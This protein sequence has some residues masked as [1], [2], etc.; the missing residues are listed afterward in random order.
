MSQLLQEENIQQL[1]EQSLNEQPEQVEQVEQQNEVQQE[2][3][4]QDSRVDH[5]QRETYVIVPP[6]KQ[7]EDQPEIKQLIMQQNPNKMNLQEDVKVS[8][9][10]KE[11]NKKLETE[12]Q[13]G[14]KTVSERTF[15]TLEQVYSKQHT[16]SLLHFRTSD[17]FDTKIV[18]DQIN[19][20]HSKQQY[21]FSKAE[22]FSKAKESYCSIQFYDSQIE[23]Q[24]NKRAAALGYGNKSDF[25]K[26]DK[27]IPGPTDYNF[28]LPSNPGVK[29]GYGRDETIIKGIHGRP[30]KNPAPN[31]YQVKDIVTTYKYSMGERTS[32]KHIYLQ[33]TTPAPGRYDVGGLKAK[34]NYF[35]GRYKSSGAPIISPSSTIAKRL[36]RIPG[37]GTYDPPG[38][39]G[40]LRTY[41]PSQYS[42]RSGFRFGFQE[43]Q[44]QGLKNIQFPGPGTYQLPSEFGDF[45]YPPLI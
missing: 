41:L 42:N 31:L 7:T 16:K 30:N 21:T 1:D 39:I 33:S 40:D 12:K 14:Q 26:K 25:T 13:Q 37:P 36:K 18:H 23:T 8:T 22:R 29:F 45:E 9:Q 20:S 28:K 27:Y 24:L 11:L 32:A 4:E 35:I 19:R 38:D 10:R 6:K 43:R 17:Q 34:G 5:N 2:Q 44:T 3:Q 15:K